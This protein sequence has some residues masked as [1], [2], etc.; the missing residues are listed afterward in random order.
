VRE[1]HQAPDDFIRYTPFG[2]QLKL[3]EHG[4]ETIRVATE[5]GPF[6]VIAYCWEQAL[7]YL[8]EEERAERSRW[9]WNEHFPELLRLDAT[10]QTNLLRRNSSFPMAFSM[11]ARRTA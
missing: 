11:T 4:F 8:P 3:K 10:H 2:L 7:Q 9:F 5:G 6:Q 1:L